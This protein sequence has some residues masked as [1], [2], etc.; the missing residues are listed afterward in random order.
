MADFARSPAPSNIGE[1]TLRIVLDHFPAAQEVDD[2]GNA[3]YSRDALH[4]LQMVKGLRNYNAG[5][6]TIRRVIKSYV[7]APPSADSPPIPVRRAPGVIAQDA[8]TQSTAITTAVDAVTGRFEDLS[9]AL[10]GL[11]DSL[12]HFSEAADH[13]TPKPQKYDIFLGNLAKL[14]ELSRKARPTPPPVA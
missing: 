3:V 5:R 8:R 6:E 1:T 4:L 13:L 7:P 10:D 14:A 9:S 12:A 11:S 2:Q